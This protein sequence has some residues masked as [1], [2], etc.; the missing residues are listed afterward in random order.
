MGKKVSSDSS[1]S[2][3]SETSEETDSGSAGE[4]GCFFA[5]SKSRSMKKS[6]SSKSIPVSHTEDVDIARKLAELG[7]RTSPDG[8]EHVSR[9][10]ST[11]SVNEKVNGTMEDSKEKEEEEEEEVEEQKEGEEEEE[12]NDGLQ[13]WPGW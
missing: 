8:N 12:E 5:I 7:D 2:S 1:T 4:E 3:E 13:R 11:K 9:A 6:K 10:N